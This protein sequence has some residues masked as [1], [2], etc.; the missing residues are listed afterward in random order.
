MVK[1]L[2]YLSIL[3]FISNAYSLH[4]NTNTENK[5]ISNSKF[6]PSMGCTISLKKKKHI[7][8]GSAFSFISEVQNSLGKYKECKKNLKLL[9]T[10]QNYFLKLKFSFSQIRKTRKKLPLLW[11]NRYSRKSFHKFPPN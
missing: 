8:T 5:T 11:Y 3:I 2:I 6:N 4:L 9:K 1:Q 10:Y 7:D